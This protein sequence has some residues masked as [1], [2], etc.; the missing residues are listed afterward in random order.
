[1]EASAEAQGVL[2][3][4]FGTLQSDLV[5]ADA[6]LIS[7]NGSYGRLTCYKNLTWVAQ[8]YSAWVLEVQ[9]QPN[10]MLYPVGTVAAMGSTSG[11]GTFVS[12]S[13]GAA[14]LLVQA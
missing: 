8:F 6:L 5:A 12:F 2:H 10:N 1:M 14:V 4:F 13:K 11:E 3:L 7:Q 9:P